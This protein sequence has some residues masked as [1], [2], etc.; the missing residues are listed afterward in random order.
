ME[1]K[2]YIVWYA[3]SGME[4]EGQLRLEEPKRIL[5]KSKEEAL[6]KYNC[7]DAF[8]KKTEPY[9]MNLTAHKASDFP[10]GGWGNNVVELSKDEYCERNFWDEK[11]EKEGYNL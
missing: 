8:D 10:S 4:T 6:Y 5:A 2:K 11:Y 7:Y 9:W 3:Y 1:I